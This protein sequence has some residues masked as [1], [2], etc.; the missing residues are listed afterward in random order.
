MFVVESFNKIIY[1]LILP[2]NKRPLKWTNIWRRKRQKE[3]LT[4]R[5][6]KS[7]SGD[8]TGRKMEV[9]YGNTES[10]MDVERERLIRHEPKS[11]G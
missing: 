10:M 4:E 6:K 2:I 5:Q 11:K 3:K 7:R 9:Q 1:Q 8:S